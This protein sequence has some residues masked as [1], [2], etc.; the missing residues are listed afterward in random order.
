ML[1]L[2]SELH[3]SYLEILAGLYLIDVG[4]FR[5]IET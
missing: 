4:Y 2:Q 1:K 5:E 3:L